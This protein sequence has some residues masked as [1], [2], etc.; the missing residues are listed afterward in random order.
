MQTMGH[1]GFV[2]TT[3]NIRIDLFTLDNP[4]WFLHED[5][6]LDHNGIITA[7][8]EGGYVQI[9]DATYILRERPERYSIPPYK[10][11]LILELKK[12]IE[13]A[14]VLKQSHFLQNIENDD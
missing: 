1:K 11:S 4:D 8:K 10:R 12:G 6:I 2:E 9:A 3:N 13:Y 7:T 14:D 5:S